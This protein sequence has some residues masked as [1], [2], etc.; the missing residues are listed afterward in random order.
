MTSLSCLLKLN[1]WA[2]L[3]FLWPLSHHSFLPQSQGL[4]RPASLFTAK[5]TRNMAVFM[6][7][8]GFVFIHSSESA[9]EWQKRGAAL[10]RLW[11]HRCVSAGV[12]CRGRCGTV[13]QECSCRAACTS[14]GNCCADFHLSCI[15]VSPYS[16]CMLGG[17]A[18]RILHLDP[19]PG[20]SLSCRSVC[21]CCFYRE[22][23]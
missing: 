5:M 20:G 11:G 4:C 7:V 17:R 16:S 19:H 15:Q 6:V 18:L 1:S 13:L 23:E 10:C 2:D 21:F 8:C 14:M 22:T 9:G 12:T 3:C